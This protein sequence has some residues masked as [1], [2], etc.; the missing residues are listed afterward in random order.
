MCAKPIRSAGWVL[1]I[2]LSFLLLIT[3]A[4]G[5]AETI[6]VP[7]YVFWQEGCPHCARAK[8]ALD[9]IDATNGNVRVQNIELGKSKEN[10]TIFRQAIDML[11]VER[12]AL[13]LVVVGGAYEVGFAGSGI[14]A[15]RYRTLIDLC[16]DVPCVDPIGQLIRGQTFPDSESPPSTSAR[17]PGSVTLPVLGETD[18]EAL[19]LPLLT[20]VLA[21]VDG[22][23]PC[24]MWVLVLLIGLLLGVR[25][26]KRM[27]ILGAVF[28]AATGVM[29]FAVM[30]AWLNVV[31]WLGA[32]AWLRLAISALAIG[33]GF[34]YLREY[35]TNPEG[36]CRVTP[37]GQRK[38]ISDSFRA[39]VEQ[40][41]LVV[42]AL[43][44][45]LLAV[46]VNVVELACS[47]GLPAVYTQSLAMH[48]LSAGAYYGYLLLYLS[49]FLL[50][51][52]IIFVTAML[53][54]RVTVTTG[55]FSRLSHLI[56]GGVLLV[57]G[58]VMAL[59]PDL[60]G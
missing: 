22:F 4:V 55:R 6:D 28:L 13:P 10:D 57:L 60:L 12:A 39:M 32:V 51:D 23:N 50:D 41:N 14:T 20:V 38:R 29:Y 53:T 45:A 8:A 17:D 48:D 33:A 3:K 15:A 52:T 30:A 9:V 36:A 40:P 1:V 43:G 46:V 34:Y 2:V 5:A 44:I 25:E 49:I 58:V 26:A 59:R 7:V 11:G 24:A 31:L 16:R 19:S 37:S 35:W 54:L 27:W 18:L 47:A 42:A 56:G 21:A